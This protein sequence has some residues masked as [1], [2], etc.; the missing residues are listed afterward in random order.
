[1]IDQLIDVC[2]SLRGVVTCNS[3]VFCFGYVWE[4][5][6]TVDCGEVVHTSRAQAHQKHVYNM[7]VYF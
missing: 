1:M 6:Q 2:A 4:V 3:V 7:R 5:Y